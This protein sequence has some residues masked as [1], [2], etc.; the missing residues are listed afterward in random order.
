MC[1]QVQVLNSESRGALQSFSVH[2][3]PEEGILEN[4]K[5]LRIKE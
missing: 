2:V 5:I 1:V 4:K 3:L